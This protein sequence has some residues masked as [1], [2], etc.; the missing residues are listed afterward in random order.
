MQCHDLYR[1]FCVLHN[2][3]Q[4]YAQFLWKI[5][6]L[7]HKVM[8]KQKRSV[9]AP[10]HALCTQSFTLERINRF[11]SVPRKPQNSL[12]GMK[13]TQDA[14]KLI[15]PRNGWCRIGSYESKHRLVRSNECPLQGQRRICVSSRGC[16]RFVVTETLELQKRCLE[17]DQPL[18]TSLCEELTNRKQ[19]DERHSG[20]R[21]RLAQ[22]LQQGLISCLAQSRN[23]KHRKRNSRSSKRGVQATPFVFHKYVRPN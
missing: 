3:N 8:D 1:N 21:M 15:L 13:G 6:W 4:S 20:S 11:R 14:L 9:K 10:L 7:V 5:F 12:M 19:D 23:P 17:S 2:F 22:A 16:R 18:L